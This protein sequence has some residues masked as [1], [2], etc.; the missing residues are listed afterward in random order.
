MAGKCQPG[1]RVVR[2]LPDGSYLSV[3][4][5]SKLGRRRR[6]ELLRAADEDAEIDPAEAH[7]VRVAEYDILGREGGGAGEIICVITSVLD[8]GS[9][10][11]GTGRCLP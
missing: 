8:R 7:V 1:L 9:D 4:Y 3:I 2:W 11:R 10:R 6:G 5:H